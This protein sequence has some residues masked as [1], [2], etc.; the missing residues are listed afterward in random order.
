MEEKETKKWIELIIC[1]RRAYNTP[2]PPPFLPPHPSV[3]QL[4]DVEMVHI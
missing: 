3:F 1:E 2:S 4:D